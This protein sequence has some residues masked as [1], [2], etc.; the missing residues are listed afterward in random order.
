MDGG[1]AILQGP[2][3]ERA[4]R[5]FNH[6]Q[7]FTVFGGAYVGESHGASHLVPVETRKRSVAKIAAVAGLLIFGITTATATKAPR[8]IDGLRQQPSH[9]T[10]MTAGIEDA[11]Y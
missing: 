9:Y 1:L 8:G 7:T 11:L 5:D 6:S 3:W 4:M 2:D 10:W